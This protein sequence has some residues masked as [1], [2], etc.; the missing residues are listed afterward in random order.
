MSPENNERRN[1]F[2]DEYAKTDGKTSKLSWMTEGEINSSS[3]KKTAKRRI[4]AK[5]TTTSLIEFFQK[6]TFFE[7]LDNFREW[8]ILKNLEWEQF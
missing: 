3:E 8:K 5:H 7:K 4:Y 2:V 6:I 1:F